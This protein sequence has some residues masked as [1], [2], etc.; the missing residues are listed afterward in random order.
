M[1]RWLKSSKHKVRQAKKV[2]SDD[3]VD[4]EYEEVDDDKDTADK[5]K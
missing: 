4:A 3:V 2:L 5:Q 1:N